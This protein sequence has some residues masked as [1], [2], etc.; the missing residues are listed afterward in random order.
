MAGA[1]RTCATFGL[2][3]RANRL[4]C[5]ASMPLGVELDVSMRFRVELDFTP[6]VA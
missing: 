6:D 2:P 4:N 3:D 5:S 1:V